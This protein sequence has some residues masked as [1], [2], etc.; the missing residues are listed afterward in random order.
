MVWDR[1]SATGRISNGLGEVICYRTGTVTYVSI[2]D[3]WRKSGKVDVK[4]ETWRE[5]NIREGR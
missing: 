1:L 3:R 4:R 2:L 5:N